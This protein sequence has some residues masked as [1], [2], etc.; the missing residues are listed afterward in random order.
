MTD[1]ET[2]QRWRLI[3]G[4][5]AK[6]SDGDDWPGELTGKAA[7]LDQTLEFLFQHEYQHDGLLRERTGGPGASQLTIPRWLGKVRQLFPKS[8]SETLVR[9]ALDRYRLAEVLADEETLESV[10][11][12]ID[13]LRSILTIKSLVPDMLQATVR[14][15]IRRVV[16]ELNR[17]MT[18]EV[19]R[20]FSGAISRR[21]PSPVKQS[22][23]LDV[24]RTLRENLRHFDPEIRQLLIERAYFFARTRKHHP[25]DVILLVDQ[26][27]SMVDSV[28]HSAVLAGVFHGLASLRTRLVVFDTEIVDLSDQLGDIVEILMKVQLGGG[29]D[30][31]AAVNYAERFIVNPR[32]TIVILITDF[33]EGGSA[34]DLLRATARIV[35]NGCIVLGLAAL[36]ERA[37]PAFDEELARRLEALGMSIGAMTPDRLAEWVAARVRA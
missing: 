29:T 34:S 37:E 35:G 11:P 16:E 24:P 28:I 23:N 14:R 31:A 32:R 6:S 19:K 30:I 10:E 33:Y 12:N 17:K 27:G 26:S 22:R 18:R 20:A 4:R 1:E 8:T 36:D 9:L 21:T 13:L 15:I 5:E 3:L 7:E 2:R 25:W